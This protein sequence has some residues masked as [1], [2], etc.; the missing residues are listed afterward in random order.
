[1]CSPVT[2]P[3]SHISPPS[4]TAL[5]LIPPQGS[6]LKPKGV[7]RQKVHSTHPLPTT[8][9]HSSVSVCSH[10]SPL[11]CDIPPPSRIALGLAPPQ[12]DGI[13][14][15]KDAQSQQ[16]ESQQIDPQI[17][18]QINPQSKCQQLNSEGKSELMCQSNPVLKA[19]TEVKSDRTPTG[20]CKEDDNGFDLFSE[21]DHKA[22]EFEAVEEQLTGE[23]MLGKHVGISTAKIRQTSTNKKQIAKEKRKLNGTHSRVDEEHKE[24]RHCQLQSRKRS[25]LLC[26]DGFDS[27]RSK[28]K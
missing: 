14:Q 26:V 28:E 13:N 22:D 11:Q 15:R 18:S 25:G 8:P 7:Q 3:P 24:S 9:F 1:M 6:G 2:P 4:Q 19:A 20:K 27:K 23:D 12:G 17:E 21:N 5:G 16:I 10:V